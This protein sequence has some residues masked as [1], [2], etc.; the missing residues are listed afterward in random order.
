MN[1]LSK[2]FGMIVIALTIG[3]CNSAS[4]GEKAVTGDAKEVNQVENSAVTMAIN[5]DNSLLEWVGTKPTGQHHGTVMIKSGEL[6]LNDGKIEGGS[7]VMDMT[8]IKNEDLEDPE[9]NAKLVGHLNSSDFFNTSEFPVGKFEIAE[10]KNFEGEVKE[11]EAKPTHTITGNLT[12]KDI[13]RSVTF[14]AFVEM[15]ENGFKAHTA[16]FAI[17]RAE[18]D[19]R[20]K[21]KKFFDNLKDD[22]VSDEIGIL[23][24]IE[25]GT[26]S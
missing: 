10:V 17:D 21:S 1:R 23:I 15:N 7:F 26:Q 9:W 19:I 14:N 12:I 5:T 8:S 20:Y 4:V 25:G 18:W 6:F 11:G 22:F 16:Q 3:A 13:T 24:R 2:I